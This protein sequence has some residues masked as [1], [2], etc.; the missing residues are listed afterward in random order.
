MLPESTCRTREHWPLAKVFHV[1]RG[2]AF[3]RILQV[4]PMLPSI[5][6]EA[7]LSNQNPS[8]MTDAFLQVDDDWTQTRA[9]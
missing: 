3:G 7:M 2:E 6:A 9:T 1:S 4:A 5:A 8:A